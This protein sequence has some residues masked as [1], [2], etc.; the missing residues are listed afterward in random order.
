MKA[1]ALN[2]LATAGKLSRRKFAVPWGRG[3]VQFAHDRGFCWD[4]VD[5]VPWMS[6]DLSILLTY[7]TFFFSK[8]IAMSRTKCGQCV[9]SRHHQET[10]GPVAWSKEQSSA[11]HSPDD[12]LTLKC[13]VYAWRRPPGTENSH[14]CTEQ[15]VGGREGRAYLCCR[16]CTE[17]K[18]I[19]VS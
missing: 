7:L 18:T 6:R 8:D 4:L 10:C 9:S 11:F 16:C 15:F 17:V 1:S 19:I 14:R 2:V 3:L 13:C 12:I 5:F